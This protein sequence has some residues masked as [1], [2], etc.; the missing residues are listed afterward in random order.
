MAEVLLFHHIQGLTDGVRGVRRRPAGRW[1][2]RARA[3]PV[4]RPAPSARSRTASSTRRV[5]DGDG[6]ASTPRWRIFPPAWSTP[7]SPGACRRRSG[8]PRR[9]PGAKGALL[10]ES[11]IP[12]TGEWAFGPW[13]DGV[14]VQIHGMDERR[15]L[16]QGGRLAAARE[17]VEIARAGPGRALHL[18]R[19]RAP[20]RRPQPA[21]VRRRGGRASVTQRSL[22]FLDRVSPRR[23][24]CGTLPRM[25]RLPRVV[26]AV[27]IAALVAA[28]GLSRCT[29]V[30]HSEGDA[31]V[32]ATGL[33]VPWGLALPADRRRAG[34]RADDG[35]HLPDPGRGRRADARRH[36]ARR[37]AASARAGCSGSRWTR[38]SSTTRSSTPT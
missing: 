8:W 13:P 18:P 19:R 35:R 21:V 17:I 37:R 23:A 27:G 7:A 2:H 12:I 24:A 36:R 5:V 29:A 26:A 20:V 16:R 3:G 28:V 15:V 32:M 30:D 4:R 6:A 22:A 11:C 14:P 10:Y 1:A 25:G 31:E 33:E 34:G 9:A 38:C